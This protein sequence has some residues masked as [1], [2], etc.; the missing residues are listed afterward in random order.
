[1]SDGYAIS[2]I[3][4]WELALLFQTGR[5]RGSGTIERRVEELVS[6]VAPSVLEITAEIASMAAQFPESY[7]RDAAD[8][9]I[10]ATARAY[11]MALITKDD[12]ISESRLVRTL[13]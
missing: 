6:L 9:L 5:L 8:R 12:R 10:G 13:W 3:T 1:M 4:F 2:S 11:D 7:P